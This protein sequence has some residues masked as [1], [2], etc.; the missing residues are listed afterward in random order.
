MAVNPSIILGA[1]NWNDGSTKIFK[2]AYDEFPWYSEGVTGFVDVND[3]ANAIIRLMESNISGEKFILNAA[4]KP[5]KEVFTLIA[6]A[7]SKKPPH[8]KVSRLMAGIVWRADAIKSMFTGSQPLLTKETA[9]AAQSIILY[10]NS[11]LKKHLPSF[12]Y[13]PFEDS[14]YRICSE[15]K[16]KNRLG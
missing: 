8:K 16:E 11:K 3:V 9:E 6:N 5:Y 12:N 4:N 1:G 13:T 7:F 10:D 2:T 14:I 15:L